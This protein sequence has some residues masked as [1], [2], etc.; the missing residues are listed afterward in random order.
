VD[1]VRISAAFHVVAAGVVSPELLGPALEELQNRHLELAACVR[2]LKTGALD[3]DKK[4]EDLGTVVAPGL[5][6]RAE[7]LEGQLVDAKV[8]VTNTADEIKAVDIRLH[9]GFRQEVTN[10]RE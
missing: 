7:H 3:H 8:A 4:L 10:L 2:A 1:A 6:R 9:A 5:R